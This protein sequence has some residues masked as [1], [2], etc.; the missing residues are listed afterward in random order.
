MSRSQRRYPE[1][2]PGSGSFGGRPTPS[3]EIALHSRHTGGQRTDLSRMVVGGDVHSEL[4]APQNLQLIKGD[5]DY[6]S[7]QI[8]DKLAL[9]SLTK[10]QQA[11][12][13]D[14]Y[15]DIHTIQKVIISVMERHH[16]VAGT[17][18]H[19]IRLLG[20]QGKHNVQKLLSPAGS[21][22]RVASGTLTGLTVNLTKRSEEI[23]RNAEPPV[24]AFKALCHTMVNYRAPD[25]V[26]TAGNIIALGVAIQGTVSVQEI[27]EQQ[28]PTTTARAVL[29]ISSAILGSATANIIRYLGSEAD[30]Y[31]PEARK[32]TKEALEGVREL[33]YQLAQALGD[34]DQYWKYV[35]G[36]ML[37]EGDDAA[38]V[39]QL[40][41]VLNMLDRHVDD[42][43]DMARA[44]STHIPLN[45]LV[46]RTRG[47]IEEERKAQSLGLPVLPMY[48]DR[49]V[50]HGGYR[51]LMPA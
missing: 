42:C 43:L 51:S 48:P 19:T 14:L 33:V 15:K 44:I 17:I 41:Q 9:C 35:H 38:D 25:V 36:R 46:L 23:K 34:L 37:E 39:N 32:A 40:Y 2:Q 3:N 11:I 29:S 6:C 10:G 16:E 12:R 13:D 49:C 8:K 20:P 50:T 22:V 27:A 5:L 21:Y 45:G 18:R 31:K 24:S 7:A 47:E 26:S 1:V 28:F 4:L 30:V